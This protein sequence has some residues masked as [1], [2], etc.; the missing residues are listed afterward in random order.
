MAIPVT[1][2]HRAIDCSELPHVAQVNVGDVLGLTA[3]SRA[4][5]QGYG[6][7]LCFE[8]M[9]LK[10]ILLVALAVNGIIGLSWFVYAVLYRC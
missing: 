6:K 5:R 2:A 7:T 1:N 8:S 10:H 3:F 4:C 9:E